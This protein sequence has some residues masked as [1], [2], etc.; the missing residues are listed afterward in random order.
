MCVKE[1]NV[2]SLPDIG[3]VLS[4]SLTL[5]LPPRNYLIYYDSC[6]Y[7][8]VSASTM[9]ILGNV[10]MQGLTVVF[11]RENNE[12]GFAEVTPTRLHQRLSIL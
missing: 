1:D 6:F 9:A 12:L 3:F 11:D 5:T 10:A 4:G 8:G 2:D 7:W